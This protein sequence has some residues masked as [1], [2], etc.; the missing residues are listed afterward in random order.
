MAASGD[1]VPRPPGKACRE[2]IRAAVM[3]DD[4]GQQRLRAAEDRLAPAASAARAEVAQEGE[5]SLARVELAQESRDA[6]MSEVC[7]TNNAES[8]KPRI[9]ESRE[10]STEAISRMEYGNTPVGGPLV[11]AEVNSRSEGV[12]PSRK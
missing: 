12:P 6:E 4:A 3:C 10:D 1:E 2:C 11:S 5:V 7:V 9:D 8:V